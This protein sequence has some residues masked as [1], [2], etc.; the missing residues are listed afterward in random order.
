MNQIVKQ[1]LVYLLKFCIGT[2]IVIWILLQIDQ[3]QFIDYFLNLN[4]GILFVIIIL[5][6]VSLTVQFNRWKYL[7]LSNSDNFE[8]KE[9]LP[10][11]FAGFAFRLMVPGGHAE[12]SKIFLLS[13]KKRGKAVAFGMEK[14]FQT[15]LKI[16]LIL[17]VLPLTFPQYK[18]YCIIVLILLV[19]GYIFIPKIPLLKNLQEKEVN[20]YRV[21]AITALF[22]LGIFTV[23]ALQYYILLNQ[24]NVI[25]PADTVHTVIY[26]WGAGIIPISISGLGIREGLAVYFLQIYGISAAHAV[27]TSLFLFTLN[28][29]IPAIIGVYFINKKKSYFA[30]FKNSVKSTREIIQNIRNGK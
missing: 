9:L 23:M 16:S 6:V 2:A 28:T 30:D 19:I 26:L 18:P 20:N 1:K 8:I 4:V 10:S 12:I 22:S 17:A 27:A 5:S 14:F 3:R 11:F 25:S 7:V 24:I 15:F 29:I 21:F 13:G